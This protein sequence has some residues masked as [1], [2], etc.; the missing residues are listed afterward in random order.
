M[1]IFVRA[2]WGVQVNDVVY[3][4]NGQ[5]GYVKKT[6]KGWKGANVLLAYTD[7]KGKAKES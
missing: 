6:F 4:P 3:A 2:R 7:N 1:C 5:A